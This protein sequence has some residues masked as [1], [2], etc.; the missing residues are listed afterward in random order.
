MKIE[1]KKLDEIDPHQLAYY[2][3]DLRVNKY[4]RNSFPYPYQ[5]N[6]ALSFIHYSIEHH[7]LDFAIVVD[8]V[9]IG[10]IGATFQNDIHQHNCELGYWIG[11]DYWNKGIMSY[12]LPAMCDYIFECF[13][14]HKIIAEVFA[15]NTASCHLLEKFSFIKEGYLSQYLYKN[16]QY[17]DAIIYSL[18][19]S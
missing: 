14:I 18:L 3:N 15:I 2:A 7:C 10:C 13:D 1:L 17:F 6:D 12:V 19:K 4:L 16:G 8:D 9:C 5:L 11:A